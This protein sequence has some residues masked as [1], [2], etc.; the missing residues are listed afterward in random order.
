MIQDSYKYKGLRKALAAELKEKGITDDKVLKAI[1][2]VPR[3]IFLDSSLDNM[4]YQDKALPIGCNQTISQ[5]MT[6]AFQSQLL[7][8]NSSDSV[9]EIGTG[10]GYQTC[11]LCAMGIRKVFS[12]ER[13]RPLYIKAKAALELLH[14]NAKCFFADGYKGL[15]AFAPFDKILITCGAKEIP[16]ALI[17]QLKIGGVLVVPVGEVSQTMYRITKTVQNKIEKEKFGSF[18]FVPMLEN[19]E[20]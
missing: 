6:V 2:E 7:Q 8:I 17:D 15:E 16:Q 14:Y 1:Q 13:Q 3:H 10:S 5:P 18:K 4:A 12:I 20:S 19:R 9:L 11:V